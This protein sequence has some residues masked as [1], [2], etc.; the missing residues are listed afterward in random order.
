MKV[1]YYYSKW[2][3]VDCVEKIDNGRFLHTPCRYVVG[4]ST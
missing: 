3:F 4:V 1:E 2:I